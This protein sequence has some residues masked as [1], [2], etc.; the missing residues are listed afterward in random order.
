MSSNKYNTNLGVSLSYSNRKLTEFPKELYKYKT[1]LIS[2]DI[3]GNPLLDLDIALNELRE[4]KSLKRLKINIETGEEAK[5]LIQALPFLQVLNDI[6]IQQEEEAINE[7][8][9]NIIEQNNLKEDAKIKE[10]DIENDFEKILEKIK[11]YDN[12]T[13]EKFDLIINDYNKLI[14]KNNIRNIL[15]ICSFFNKILINLIKDAQEKE[16][17]K[18]S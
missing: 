3:S 14:S 15:E 8:K 6:K 10:K 1:N 9:G 5:K 13:K 11:E 18:I 16:N 7:N 2:L 4:F 12:I 17:I